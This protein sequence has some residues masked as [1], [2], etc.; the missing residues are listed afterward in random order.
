M[1]SLTH[2]FLQG[3]QRLWFSP[4]FNE[5]VALASFISPVNWAKD[6]YQSTL[7]TF[8]QIP[9]VACTL[10]CHFPWWE[11]CNFLHS[12][13]N[14][15][16]NSFYFLFLHFFTS[17]PLVQPKKS[18]CGC[19]SGAFI[20]SHHLKYLFTHT[21]IVLRVF[22]LRQPLIIHCLYP[23]SPHPTGTCTESSWCTDPLKHSVQ[24]DRQAGLHRHELQPA[25]T[26]GRPQRRFHQPPVKKKL[27]TLPRAIR[28]SDDCSAAGK[29]HLKMKSEYWL[30][31]TDN[32][33]KLMLCNLYIIELVEHSPTANVQSSTQARQL[34]GMTEN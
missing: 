24:S 15:S 7:H 10:P 17:H 2:I 8:F 11:S 5:V 12:A 32:A 14:T 9:L 22:F 28:W 26:H 33:E 31:H 1:F 34:A 4:C 27:F 29:G 20:P 23:L 30:M 18:L 3:L 6:C 16:S 13:P 25:C 19:L 21:V